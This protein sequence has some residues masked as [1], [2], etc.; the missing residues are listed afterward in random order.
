VA[1]APTG[2]TSEASAGRLQRREETPPD[3][4]FRFELFCRS[5]PNDEDFSFLP[6]DIRQ[7]LLRQQFLAQD[8]GYRADF[9]NARFEIIE[10][11]GQSVGRVVTVALPD[12]LFVL[13]VAILPDWQGRGIGATILREICASA[14]RDGLAARLDVLV[15]NAQALRLFRR[16]GFEPVA[17]SE[18]FMTLESSPVRASETKDAAGMRLS[19]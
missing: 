2:R 7:T 9:P 14:G 1:V 11:D 15:S 12:S 16:L 5:R 3:G 10:C 4:D 18:V 17:R 19:S 6:S 8:A 13:D